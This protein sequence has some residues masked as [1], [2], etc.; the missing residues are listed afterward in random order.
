MR[1]FSHVSH[2]SIKMRLSRD[3]YIPTISLRNEALFV[4]YDNDQ[5]KAYMMIMTFIRAE[6]D[7]GH[8]RRVFF[9]MW[10]IQ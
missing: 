4:N 9:N 6:A 10:H 8:C 1:A 2:L 5:D 7:E 3:Y